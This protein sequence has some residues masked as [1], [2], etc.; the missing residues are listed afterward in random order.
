MAAGESPTT[1]PDG[2]CGM[3]D[4]ATPT[5]QALEWS[6]PRIAST[7]ITKRSADDIRPD[8]TDAGKLELETLVRRQLAFFSG[9][10]PIGTG[11]NGL[12]SGSPT[13]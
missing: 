3:T 6:G 4:A 1:A 5:A 8:I 10:I 12:Q 2:N 11:Y 13:R 9:R 7:V